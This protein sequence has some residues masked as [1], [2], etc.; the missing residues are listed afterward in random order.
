MRQFLFEDTEHGDDGELITFTNGVRDNFYVVQSKVMSENCATEFAY[1]VF[2]SFKHP[3]TPYVDRVSQV[4]PGR[5]HSY[6]TV[7]TPE[8]LQQFHENI[9]DMGHEGTIIRKLNAPYKFGRVTWNEGYVLK[10]VDWTREEGIIRGFRENTMW[11]NRIGA[12][13]IHTDKWGSVYLGSGFNHKLSREFAAHPKDFIGK[14]VT[15][16]YKKER[17]KLAPSQPIFVGFYE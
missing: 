10:L 11:P 8:Q 3:N 15:F 4:N 14:T 17:S 7:Y 5:R 1:R 6:T 16:K 2:D 12:I 13:V 9:T